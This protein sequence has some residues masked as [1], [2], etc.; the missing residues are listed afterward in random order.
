MN[1]RT[2]VA[3]RRAV[4]AVRWSVPV[5]L[6]AALLAPVESIA[7]PVTLSVVSARTEPAWM[8]VGIVAGTPVETY[9]YL[10]N[11]DDTGDVHQARTDGCTPEAV[12]YPAGCR[13]PSV[14]AISS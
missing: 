8:G 11:V 13:W 4:R 9:R 5:L 12:D 7:T 6:A 14:A 2:S 1:R 3:T 10:I